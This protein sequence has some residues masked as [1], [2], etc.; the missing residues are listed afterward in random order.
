MFKSTDAGKTWTHIGLDRH[1]ADRPHRRRPAPTPIAST[2]P[3]SATSTT[4]TPS[5]AS[6][7]PPTAA[8]T[9]RRSSSTPA[10]PNDVGAV[11][12]AIDPKNPRSRSTPR[13]GPRAVRHGRSTLP[14]TCPAAAST[15]PPTAATPGSKLT[16]G[17][18]TDDFVGKIGIAVAPSN[19]N[20][21]WAVVDDLGAR[22]RHADPRRRPSD[23]AAAKTTGGGI[24]ISDDAGATW[25]L[26]NSEQPSLGPRLVLRPVTVDPT[27]PDRAYVINTATYLTTD[28]GKTLVPV[29]G[30]PGGDDYHQIWINPKD[31]NRMVLSAAIRAPSS[32]ST[33]RRPGAPGTTSPPRRSI[34]SPPTIASPTGSTAR[35]RTPAA[36]ASAPGRAWA[37]SQLPQLGAHLP[38]RRKQHRRPRSQRRQHPLR[39][40]RRRCD[41]TLNIAR[42]AR[43]RT[44][45]RPT[46]T[47]PTARPGRSRRSSPPA[48]EAL[49]YSN[50]FVF[51]SRDRGKTWQKI[52]PDLTRVNPEVPDRPRS[53]HREGHRPADDRSLR[54]RLHHRPFAAR[55]Q[56]P[57]GSAPTTASSTS[58]RDDGKN[59]NNVTPPAMTAWSKVSQI[60]AGHFDVETAYA[61]VDRHRIA[62]NKPY[63]YRTHDGG[64]TWT[65]HRQRHP[66]RRLRQLRQGRPQTK[67]PALRRHRAARLRLLR[68]R[69]PVAAAAE[70]HARHLRARHRR[71]RRRSRRRHPRPRLLG[72]GSDDA[73]SARSPPRA[74]RS[75]PPAPTSSSPASPS[76]SARAAERHAAPARRAAGAQPTRR[77]PR[78]LLA[79]VGP[80][81][82][83]SSSSS[84]TATGTVRACVASDTPVHPVDT[85]AINVQAI[86]EQPTQPPSAEAGMHRFAL[87]VAAPARLRRR[88]TSWS[89]RC[90]AP[91]DACS[92]PAGTAAR[93]SCRPARGATA[94]ALDAGLQPGDYTVRLTVDGQTYTQPV[95]VKPDPRGVPDRSRQ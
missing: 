82:A 57:S 27:N 80:P 31:G 20:R 46:P 37:C 42:L 78:L 47:I 6:I 70:Q 64:K 48:D 60:E 75:P 26:V 22:R 2:S 15:N 3:R 85:E 56:R 9:G 13:S 87:N 39:Q 5:A 67:G 7:A 65:E 50:Q 71:P 76:P 18:P 4:P 92:P 83:R 44:A 93:S 61:S 36:S 12:L 94:A 86:W 54:R 14:P 91:H 45:R 58:P 74:T 88:R 53:R 33:A 34:T 38:R 40:R 43:R 72:P 19:P 55:A 79:Q 90:T 41:Q 32:A 8:R 23:G 49:Y 30:A 1:R 51:R 81:P 52:S 28:A 17:L 95:T 66:R 73:H 24:Y 69:R 89:R 63:I 29:K 25:K 11:D 59:W 21:L 35:S 62:D 77:R 16:G 10:I 68:R 84:S